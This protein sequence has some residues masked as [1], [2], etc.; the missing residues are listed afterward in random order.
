MKNK[1]IYV[2]FSSKKKKNQKIKSYTRLYYKLRN[3]IYY[4]FK[5][6]KSIFFKPSK[7]PS[8]KTKENFYRNN[9]FNI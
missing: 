2:D 5:K 3:Y 1:V 6:L 8:N 7:N 4:P 9:F